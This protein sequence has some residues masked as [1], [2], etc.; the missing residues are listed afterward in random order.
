M[1]LYFSYSNFIKKLVYNHLRLF[2]WFVNIGCVGWW[3]GGV[4][5]LVGQ[6]LV[7]I[8]KAFFGLGRMRFFIDLII[9]LLRSALRITTI[10]KLIN[11]NTICFFWSRCKRFIGLRFLYFDKLLFVVIPYF[12]RG[13]SIPFATDLYI[14]FHVCI[15]TYIYKFASKLIRFFL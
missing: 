10:F 8:N 4:V 13:Y 14:F 11:L 1:R 6:Y 9:A 15:L 12:G 7:V 5:A 2:S 3:A